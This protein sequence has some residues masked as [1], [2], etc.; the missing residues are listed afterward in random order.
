MKYELEPDN[1]NCPDEVLLADLH[2]VAQRLDI[3]SLTKEK[4]DQNGRFSSA[5]M[6]KRFGSWNKAL[7][8]SGL[9][10]NK[11]M[12]I[13]LEEM[14]SDM[15]RVAEILRLK[16]V[17][18]PLYCSHGKFDRNT[19]TRAYGTWNK[20]LSAAGLEPSRHK[21]GITE[22]ELFDNMAC[23]C[24]QVGHQPRQNDF[25]YP[26]SKYSHGTYV[27]RYGSW[28]NALEAFVVAANSDTDERSNQ[29][30]QDAE[31][32][33]S[34][35]ICKPIHR[36]SRN[37]SWRLRF[38][39]MRRDDF[40]CRIDGRSPATHPGTILEVDH[41]TAWDIGGE[42]VMENL[43]TLCQKCNGGKSDL[44]LNKKEI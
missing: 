20:A 6:R 17:P 31:P 5:T 38:L 39:V 23:V 9:V 18:S 7:A 32:S 29:V 1:R 16:T 37:P 25:C 40:K 8:R 13:P 33:T 35:S 11:R 36:T 19:I 42:T 26:I 24:E 22:E 4:Y 15:R 44:P 27:G 30:P 41:I 28:R 12:N 21:R 3:P 14:L 34:L 43:Q 10:V 2:A